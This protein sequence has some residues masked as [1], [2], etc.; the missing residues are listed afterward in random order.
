MLGDKT[1]V[2]I[3][4]LQRVDAEARADKTV[5]IPFDKA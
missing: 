2:L 4:P 3:P 1:P 5:H